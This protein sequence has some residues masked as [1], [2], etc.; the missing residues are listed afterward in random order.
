MD[1]AN[2]NLVRAHVHLVWLAESGLSLGSAM[3][4]ILDLADGVLRPELNSLVRDH[5]KTESPGIELESGS[6]RCLPT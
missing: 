4:D 2:E 5:L 6:K 1:L 3:G